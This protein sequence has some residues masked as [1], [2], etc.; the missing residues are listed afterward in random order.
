MKRQALT[1]LAFVAVAACAPSL[2]DEPLVLDGTETGV[3]TVVNN[4]SRPIA[5]LNMG[6]CESDW[7]LNRLDGDV[8]GVGQ[9]RDFVVSAGC[10]GMLVELGRN[11]ITSTYQGLGETTVAAG[12][13]V[14]VVVEPR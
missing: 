2:K 9:S 4:Q 13:T 1:L 3:I 5:S 12:E 6:R 7:R 10:Y 14:V 8:I 11:S